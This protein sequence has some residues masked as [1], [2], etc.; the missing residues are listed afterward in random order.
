M[1]ELI[2]KLTRMGVRL[3]CVVVFFC[4]FFLLLEKMFRFYQFDKIYVKIT[5]NFIY[6]V[7]NNK[8]AS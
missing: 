3:V 4:F 1:S 5:D 2:A 7:I 8:A 6:Q